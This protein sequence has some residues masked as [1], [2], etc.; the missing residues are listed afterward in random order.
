MVTA[1]GLPIDGS[2]RPAWVAGVASRDQ[3]Q[4]MKPR[5]L[6]TVLV[7]QSGLTS[8]QKV[9]AFALPTYMT[10][11]PVAWPSVAE[12]VDAT[13]LSER[14]VRRATADLEVAGWVEVDR[15]RRPRT[16]RLCWPSLRPD[17]MRTTGH[18]GRI[19][20]GHGGRLGEQ[21]ATDDTTTGHSGR[22][23]GH[24]G[25][26]KETRKETRKEEGRDR[27]AQRCVD[28][29]DTPPRRQNETRVEIDKLLAK[30]RRQHADEIIGQALTDLE[31]AG[32]TGDYCDSQLRP[33]LTAKL[34]RHRA[35]SALEEALAQARAYVE[36]GVD[37]LSARPDL[38]QIADPVV[39]RAAVELYDRLIAERAA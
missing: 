6:W 38:E 29:L 34:G 33:A 11:P 16:V 13:G 10:G 26:R 28:L 7:R 37:P 25:P 27:L 8:S 2:A 21:P 35:P 9:L 12:L 24:C 32:W 19:T 36:R 20:T 17:Q 31:A 22:T 4:K 3:A 15:A 18:S 14:A 30:L 1:A 23:T 39:A 5:S